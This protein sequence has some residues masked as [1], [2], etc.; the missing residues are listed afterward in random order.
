M[1]EELKPKRKVRAKK[2]AKKVRKTVKTVKPEKPLGGF[3]DFIRTQGVIGLAIGLVLGVQI[4][5]LVDSFIAS[6]INPILGLVLPGTGDLS[7]K[8]FTLTLGEKTAVFAYGSFIVVL[9]S[10]IV[11]AAVVY[12]MFRALGLHKLDKKKA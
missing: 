8:T 4:K 11:V 7:N 12:F 5:A 6:F 9:I 2:V 3:V 1:A 10:F